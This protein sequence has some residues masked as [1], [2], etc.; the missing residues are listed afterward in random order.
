MNRSDSET[1][2]EEHE[3][4]TLKAV[5]KERN[6]AASKSVEKTV[7][8]SPEEDEL[9][10]EDEE[11]EILD[12]EGEDA[13]AQ[14]GAKVVVSEGDSREDVVVP[15]IN[16]EPGQFWHVTVLPGKRHL[17]QVMVGTPRSCLSWKFTTEKK[18]RTW[19]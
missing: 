7:R 10:E 12:S 16:E 19:D 5:K 1:S 2:H 8:H 3:Y 14:P 4:T 13:C 18:V 6:L 9:K 17:I 11:Y 15:A